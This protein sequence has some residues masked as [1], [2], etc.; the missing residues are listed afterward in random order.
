MRRDVCSYFEGSMTN[1]IIAVTESIGEMEN[2]CHYCNISLIVLS[3][4]MPLN[5]ILEKYV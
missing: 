2:V 3:F 5:V 1:C 4:A